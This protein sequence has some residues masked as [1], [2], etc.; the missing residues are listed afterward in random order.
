MIF[1]AGAQ[2]HAEQAAT[3]VRETMEKRKDG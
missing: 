2:E 3:M 1:L